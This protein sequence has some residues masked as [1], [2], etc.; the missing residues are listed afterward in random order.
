MM[1]DLPS[2][3]VTFLFTDIEGSTRL[4]QQYPHA[5]PALLARHHA[6]LHQAIEAHHGYV[7]QI[8]GDAFH[9]AFYT[10]SDALSAALGAQRALVHEPWNPVAVKVRM[11]IN[12]GR[13]EAGATEERA[14]GYTGYLTLTRAERVMSL[15][16]GGQI[17]LS[18]ASAELVRGE[19][20]ADAVL[21]DMQEHRLKGLLNPE[22][23]WQVDTPDLPHEF[24]QLAS[25]N[26]VPTNLP[27]QLTSFVGR[28]KEIAELKKLLQTTR[29]VTLTGSG[30]TGK[31]RLSLQVASEVLDSFK[32]GVSLVELAPIADPALV[33][34]TVGTALGIRE[35]SGRAIQDLLIDFLH[36]KQLLLILDNC[37]HLIDTCAQLADQLLRTCSTLRILASSREA[38]GIAGEHV[39]RVPSLS[40]AEL[41]QQPSFEGIKHNDCVQLFVERALAAQAAFHLTEKNAPAIAQVCTR[42]DGIPLAI[43][44]AAARIKLFAPDQIAAR[45]DDRFRLLTGGSRTALPRQQTLRAL[46]DWSYDLLPEA[47]RVLL[48]RLSVF[49]GGWTYEAAGAVCAGDG[50]E[51]FEVLDLLAHLVDKSLVAVDESDE[52]NA[53]YR[54][55]ETIRQYARDK[56]LD[57]GKG[58]AVRNRHLDY[59]LRFGDEAYRQLLTAHDIEWRRRIKTEEDNVRTAVEWALGSQPEEALRLS[60][61]LG[62]Y[63]A[64]LGY[65]RELSRWLKTSLEAVAALP[66]TTDE[67]A[68]QRQV[69]QARGLLALSTA[70]TTM[71]EMAAAKQYAEASLVIWSALGIQRGRGNAL[72]ELAISTQFSGEAPA[73]LAAVKEAIEI[74]RTN[75][76]PGFLAY[77]LGLGAWIIGSL[78]R[79]ILTARS[80]L[81][82]SIALFHQLGSEQSAA[83]PLLVLGDLE[84]DLGN[85]EQAHAAYEPSLAKNL[86]AGNPQEANRSRSGL[87]NAERRLGQY[88]AALKRYREVITEWQRIG[89]RGGIARCLEC[90]AFVAIGQ[91]K[92]KPSAGQALLQRAARLLGAAATLRETINASM[93]PTEQAEYDAEMASL[94][95]GLDA[96]TLAAGWKE[97]RAMT[98]ERAVAVV[99]ASAASSE[100]ACVGDGLGQTL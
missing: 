14:G 36:T 87:A 15:A 18:N 85:Y 1:T 62:V 99:V 69:N 73:A 30:G 35:L 45:L 63:W 64:W 27:Q 94:R 68:R 11:G 46:I 54:L 48:H 2:G 92:D 71:G 25:L 7:F 80:Y 6:I 98:M 97:G 34:Q 26:E 65:P 12:T 52:T 91:A 88:D 8:V 41:R 19:L 82:E 20:P 90:L 70:M 86:A 9:A 50:I 22:R 60:G 77:A 29:L 24:P 74:A 56:L 55:L 75:G 61:E 16:N 83:F 44:L 49:V 42:L 39:Y 28:E 13:A 5:M 31:T 79:D 21:R 59:F 84:Y 47:E 53:R 10:V 81:Q 43:E 58:V 51:T 96:S 78:E 76:D 93:L 3:T 57:S 4:A 72:M 17:L 23:I 66:P 67:A 40:I 100:G 89:N 32:D 38:L 37:E 33:P 95:A